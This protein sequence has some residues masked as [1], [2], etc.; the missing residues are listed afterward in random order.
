MSFVVKTQILV[1]IHE[2][3]GMV[4]ITKL[5]SNVVVSRVF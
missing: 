3:N 4:T 2:K 5:I 1:H